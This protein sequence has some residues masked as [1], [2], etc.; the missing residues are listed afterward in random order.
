MNTRLNIINGALTRMGER[1]IHDV[2]EDTSTAKLMNQIYNHARKNL[3]R[4]H[5]WSFAKKRVQLSPVTSTPTFGYQNAFVMPND[6]VRVINPHV[7]NWEIEG[8]YIL[9]DTDVLNMIYIFDND[10]E[11]EF[12]DVFVEAFIL[13]L[14]SEMCKV[15]TGSSAA[16]ELAAAKLQDVLQQARTLNGM[17]RPS[18]SIDAGYVSELIWSRY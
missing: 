3:L 8:R 7:Q 9:A 11:Q 15:I 6:L 5:P 13:H 18:Q 4:L 14:T 12:D 1:L 2:E 17:E 10:K 16:G